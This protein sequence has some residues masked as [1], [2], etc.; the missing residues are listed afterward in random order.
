VQKPNITILSSKTTYSFKQFSIIEDELLFDNGH[1]GKHATVKHNGAVVILPLTDD[2]KILFIRQYRHSVGK[3]IV[4]IPAGTLNLGED[5]SECALRELQ[6]ETGYSAKTLIPLGIVY[7]APGFCS[8]RQHLF[9]AKDLF[10]S[11]LA[12]DEDE[13]IDVAPLS[14]DEAINLIRLGEIEDSKSIAAIFKSQIL[15]VIG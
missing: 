10:E 1:R 13:I 3:V 2:G 8:E 14:L 9:F 15:G 5:P 12:G 4:E 7:P 6:E 11:R